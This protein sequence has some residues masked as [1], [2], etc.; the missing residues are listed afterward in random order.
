M[1]VGGIL[2]GRRPQG[3]RRPRAEAAAS[4]QGGPPLKKKVY[5]G[6]MVL[7]RK[8]TLVKPFF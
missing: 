8:E 7:G 4:P 5:N 1:R 6:K 3:G 2:W